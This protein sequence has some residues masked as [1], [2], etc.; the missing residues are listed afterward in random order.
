MSS[1]NEWV[2][3][4]QQLGG[5][6]EEVLR[7]ALGLDR[8][9]KGMH[10]EGAV[11]D[12]NKFQFDYENLGQ[13][14]KSVAK[15]VI[16]FYT[17]TRKNFPLQVE[18]MLKR[19]GK[20]MNAA[21]VM[22]FPEG[23]Q[24]GVVPDYFKDMWASPTPFHAGDIPGA[25]AIFGE[26]HAGDQ[27]N[28]VPDLPFTQPMTEVLPFDVGT[29]ALDLTKPLNMV[30]PIIKT[31]VELLRGSKF[32]GDLPITDTKRTIGPGGALASVPGLVSVLGDLGLAKK[33]KKTGEIVMDEDKAYALEQGLP[34]LSLL[35]R[36]FPGAPSK[37]DHALGT[38]LSLAGLPIRPVTKRDAKNEKLNRKYAKADLK[39][40]IKDDNK[41]VSP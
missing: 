39:R 33:D 36:A 9:S 5:G 6:V 2:H 14:E 11:D 28:F 12:I 21:R 23:K 25:T 32:F 20:Y 1:Q 13:F 10:L 30:T 27:L 35:Q 18:M 19:P 15:R 22:S 29:G 38:W 41:Y 37:Q 40:A 17:W 7:G 31:P 34:F 8:M 16:P 26:Q 3:A 4:N 24:E